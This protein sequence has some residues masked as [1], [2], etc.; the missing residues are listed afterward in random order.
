MAFIGQSSPDI[1]NKLQRVE[2][3]Q[4][5]TLEDLMKEAE[6]IINKRETPE[7]REERLRKIQ[8]ERE[9]RLR[10]EQ[11]EK[12]EKCDKKCSRELSKILATVVQPRAESGR[13]DRQGDNR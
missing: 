2:G 1:R 13:R 12:E 10:K 5:Y 3:L 6:K 11:E 7:E 9:D 8:E 4:D